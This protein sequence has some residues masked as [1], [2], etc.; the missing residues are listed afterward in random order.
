MYKQIRCKEYIRI[1]KTKTNIRIIIDLHNFII[2]ILQILSLSIKG[3]VKDSQSI[4][5]Y[6]ICPLLGDIS[7]KFGYLETINE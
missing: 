3:D 1:Y 7:L 4:R 6:P 5:Q 2:H